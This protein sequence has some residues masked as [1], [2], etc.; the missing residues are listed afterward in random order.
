MCN[1]KRTLTSPPPKQ[2]PADLSDHNAN[3]KDEPFH[4]SEL[5]FVVDIQKNNKIPGPDKLRM[6]LF[7]WLG[8]H[9]RTLLLASINDLVNHDLWDNTL[10]KANVASI[11]KKGD[12]SNLANYRPIS[13][14]QSSYKILAAMI[15]ERLAASIDHLITKTQYG[16]RK[17]K[18]L[19]KLYIWQED[20]WT[21][22]SKKKTIFLSYFWT[23]KKAFD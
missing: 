7:Q 15:Q 18:V 10:D 21:S 9:S 6:E 20:C 12:S 8:P 23:G 11:Y 1:G 14:L 4:I 17:A 16:F 22:R 19:L 2:H 3:I 5:N 13:L